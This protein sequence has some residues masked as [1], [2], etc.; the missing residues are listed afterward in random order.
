M[1]SIVGSDWFAQRPVYRCAQLCQRDRFE[2]LRCLPEIDVHRRVAIESYS[3][4]VLRAQINPAPQINLPYHSRGSWIGAFEHTR[5]E[6]ENSLSSIVFALWQYANPA[7]RA[8]RRRAEL[9]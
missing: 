7:L 2:V 6:A 9:Q 3:K 8:G 5:P 4:Q 1:T